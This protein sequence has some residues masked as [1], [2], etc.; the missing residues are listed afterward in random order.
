M[1][2]ATSYPRSRYIVPTPMFA[3]VLQPL[4]DRLNAEI[5]NFEGDGAVQQIAHC[6]A[7]CIGR[8]PEA[9]TRRIYDVLHGKTL[10]TSAHTADGILLALDVD[11]EQTT[12]PTFPVGPKPAREMVDI[13]FPELTE[14]E[15]R[16]LAKTLN[17]FCAGFL[18]GAGLD[19][20]DI[21][22]VYAVKSLGRFL[23]EAFKATQSEEQLEL[24]GAV[25]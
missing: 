20:D 18:M 4:V 16:K 15:A 23:R 12:I 3:E 22:E 9:I 14:F 2:P 25:A 7:D 8:A 6:A 13:H 17:H 10:K 11:I 19:L 1:E 5:D 21:L 24:V